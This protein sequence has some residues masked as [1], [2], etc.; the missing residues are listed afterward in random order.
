VDSL[1]ERFDGAAQLRPKFDLP[2]DGPFGDFAREAGVQD[3]LVGEF[4]RL[5]RVSAVAKGYSMST[6]RLRDR[7]RVHRNLEFYR[8][9]MST[10]PSEPSVRHGKALLDVLE[11][12]EAPSF[13]NGVNVCLCDHAAKDRISKKMRVSPSEAQVW[14]ATA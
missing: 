5:T 14:Q 4:N 10:G 9:A 8:P 2:R 3:Q 11:L 13:E 12:R 6:A 1:Q 7:F